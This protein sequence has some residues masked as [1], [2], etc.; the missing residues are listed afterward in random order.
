MKK[1]P[2]LE[3]IYEAYS[4]IADN[5]VTMGENK[6][7]V[8][9]SNL[10]K[11]YLV[12]WRE[13]TYTSSDSAT[14]WQ[15]YPG[16][17]VLAV[18]MLQGRLPLNRETAG[19]F[20]EINWTQLNARH[21]ANYAA[22]VDEISAERIPA[23]EAEPIRQEVRQVYETLSKLELTIKRGKYRPPAAQAKLKGGTGAS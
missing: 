15:G 17:P 2:P 10:A 21:K 1:L 14:Y 8:I 9:S 19:R 7:E 4:A 16:Y 6:A 5:R 13:N 12:T 11:T 23:S 20:G 18:L 3:K 22:A